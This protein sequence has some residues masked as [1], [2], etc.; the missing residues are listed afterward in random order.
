MSESFESMAGMPATEFVQHRGSMLLL[1]RLVEAGPEHAICEWRVNATNEFAVPCRGV[2]AYVAIECMA[3]C[4]AVH[5]GVRARFDGFAPPLGFLLGTRH[6]TTKDAY[7][8]L[9]VTYQI[10]CRELLRD[11]QGMASYE[12][13]V[14][15]GEYMVVGC[16]LAVFEKQRGLN[17][18]GGNN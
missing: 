1:D 18:N 8:E 16:R 4:V 11:T 12:C 13:R 9:G 15:R 14:M 5:A 17:L 3:Q 2:P 10:H 7:L 6:F